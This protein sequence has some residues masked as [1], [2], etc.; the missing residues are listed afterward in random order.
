MARKKTG[1]W[2]SHDF[3]KGIWHYIA[4]HSDK[5]VQGKCYHYGEWSVT[6]QPFLNK[7]GLIK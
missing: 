6:S 1:K 3:E 2:R 7:R 4:V 5:T